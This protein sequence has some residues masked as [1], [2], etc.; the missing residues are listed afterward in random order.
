MVTFT[1]RDNSSIKAGYE[2]DVKEVTTDSTFPLSIRD[3]NPLVT[4]PIKAIGSG[5]LTNFLEFFEVREGLDKILK[6]SQAIEE[7]INKTVDSFWLFLCVLKR[8][9]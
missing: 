9:N 1:K 7:G 3:G 4:I 6:E 5:T 2:G 8:I